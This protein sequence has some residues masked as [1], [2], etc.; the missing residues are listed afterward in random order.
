MYNNFLHLIH[1]FETQQLPKNDVF[2][3]ARISDFSP[4]TG[5]GIEQFHC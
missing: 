4:R 3:N 1:A 5:I 2:P